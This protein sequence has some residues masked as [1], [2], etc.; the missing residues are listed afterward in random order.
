MHVT[1][2]EGSYVAGDIN[3]GQAQEINPHLDTVQY[4]VRSILDL[5]SSGARDM[6]RRNRHRSSRL[7]KTWR[8][9]QE[10]SKKI[11]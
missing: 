3:P 9:G 10:R 6:E 7:L 1:V 2:R 5:E 4:G 8:V 11:Y